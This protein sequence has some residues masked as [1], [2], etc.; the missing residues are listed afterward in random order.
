MRERQDGMV[1]TALIKEGP[2][3]VGFLGKFKTRKEMRDNV[4]VINEEL[5]KK[6][7]GLHA[8]QMREKVE[9]ASHFG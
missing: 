2:C 8:I 1:W 7:S 4:P 9:E 3:G 5:Q 6:G